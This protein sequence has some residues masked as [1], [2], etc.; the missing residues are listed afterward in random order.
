V[1]VYDVLHVADLDVELAHLLSEGGPTRWQVQSGRRRCRISVGS[2]SRDDPLATAYARPSWATRTLLVHR[3]VPT[4]SLLGS[5]PKH[6]LSRGPCAIWR[7]GR[8]RLWLRRQLRRQLWWRLLWSG[9][10]PRCTP[11]YVVTRH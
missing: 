9:C 10:S 6:V 3:L 11:S 7:C 5:N 8:L 1:L 4:G 2:T